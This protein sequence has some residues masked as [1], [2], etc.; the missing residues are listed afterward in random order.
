VALPAE[1][2]VVVQPAFSTAIRNRHNVI[3]FPPRASG[4]PLAARDAIERAWLLTS[5]QAF[6]LSDIEAASLADPGIT[7]PDP[8]A[9][10]TRTAAHLPFVHARIAA[11]CPS[12]WADETTTPAA[13]RISRWVAIGFAPVVGSDGAAPD[14]AHAEHIG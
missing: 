5:P 14:G 12:R 8:F 7:L 3:R 2:A 4:A 9:D 1:Q 10:V 11:E 13:N 6:G